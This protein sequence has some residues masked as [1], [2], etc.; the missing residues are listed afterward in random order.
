MFVLPLFSL[1]LLFSSLLIEPVWIIRE[2]IRSVK[3]GKVDHVHPA[4]QGD[5]TLLSETHIASHGN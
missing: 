2:Q 5:R 3:Q 1:L 4:P